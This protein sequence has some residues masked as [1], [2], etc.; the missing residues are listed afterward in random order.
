[1]R[2]AGFHHVER[3]ADLG[4]GDGRFERAREALL[5]W[6][7]HLVA[8]LRVTSSEPSAGE[9]VV[10]RCGLGP[11]KIP[12]RVVWVIDEPHRCGFAYGTLPGHPESGE[13]AFVVVRD[14]GTVRLE[15]SAYSR[16]GRLSTRLA[17]PLGRGFQQL[18]TGRYAAALRREADA[19][20]H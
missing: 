18:M 6:R 19:A 10:V 8:G 12:C 11:L 4:A 1:M 13:E 7:M 2:P 14:T 15:I 16:P 3:S 17:G 5:T 20:R 9:G